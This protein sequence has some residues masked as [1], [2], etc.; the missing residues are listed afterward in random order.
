MKKDKITSLQNGRVKKWT[1]LHTKKGRDESGLFLVEGE[2]LISEAITAGIL[3]TLIIDAEC[4]FEA[5]EIYEAA[6][7]LKKTLTRLFPDEGD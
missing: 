4:P 6:A 1:S 3:K 7:F 5:D 2:H